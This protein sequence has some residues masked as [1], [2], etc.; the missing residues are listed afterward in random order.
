[1]KKWISAFSIWAVVC[2]G[3]FGQTIP[4]G[5]NRSGNQLPFFVGIHA[6]EAH[7]AVFFPTTPNDTGTGAGWQATVGF[8]PSARLAIQLGGTYGHEAHSDDPS[9]TGTTLS[10]Q[11]LDG[12]SYSKRWTYCLPVL[13]R[14]A[15]VRSPNPRLQIDALA[16]LTLLGT[17][18]VSAAENRINHQVVSSYY[19]E[20]KATQLYATAGVGLRYSFGRH[21]EG[22]LD[23]TYSRNFH[24]ASDN[25]HLSVTGNK[26][27]LTRALS[28]GLRYRFAVRK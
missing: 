24:A 3:A 20:D 26:L 25:V 9:Y 16:G 18:A 22:V 6:I 17:R 15:V 19:V 10:G 27:G 5:A 14:Y 12:S 21:L 4:S 11:Y 23:W 2:F 13:A 8:N 28:L 1:M 7:Y